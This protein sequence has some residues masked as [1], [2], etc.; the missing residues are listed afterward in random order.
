MIGV[1]ILRYQAGR[2]GRSYTADGIGFTMQLSFRQAIIVR[3]E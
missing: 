3:I 2:D 1:L